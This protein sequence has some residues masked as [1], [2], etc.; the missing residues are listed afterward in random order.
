MTTHSALSTSIPDASTSDSNASPSTQTTALNPCTDNCSNSNILC[1]FSPSSLSS[2]HPLAC[3][4][5]LPRH[6]LLYLPL[7]PHCVYPSPCF[8][9]LCLCIIRSHFAIHRW[10]FVHG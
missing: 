10:P 7:L 3:H 1:P 5:L 4:L 8:F 9:A 6:M 2:R